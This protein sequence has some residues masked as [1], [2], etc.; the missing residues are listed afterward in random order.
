MPTR[1]AN[2][3]NHAHA[4]DFLNKELAVLARYVD[5][6]IRGNVNLATLT[7]YNQKVLDAEKATNEAL[8]ALRN[9]PKEKT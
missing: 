8:A 4:L 7:R 1:E 2:R 5:G 9:S 6:F 3:I